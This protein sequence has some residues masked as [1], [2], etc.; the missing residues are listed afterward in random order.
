MTTYSFVLYVAGQTQ[1]SHEALE[2]LRSLCE[3]RLRGYYELS[4]VDAVERPELA[5]RWR[6]LATP[7]VVRLRP[8]PQRRV[9]GDLADQHRAALALGLPNP[10]EFG[11]A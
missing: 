10:D 4:V 1:R 9:V 7:T 5:E 2:N 11:G 8:A 6:I 3:A